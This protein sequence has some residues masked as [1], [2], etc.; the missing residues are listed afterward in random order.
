MRGPTPVLNYKVEVLCTHDGEAMSFAVTDSEAG[1]VV[2]VTDPFRAF[3]QAFFTGKGDPRVIQL[4][5]NASW[6]KIPIHASQVRRFWPYEKPVFPKN[7]DHRYF[8]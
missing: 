4:A 1:H 3:L 6:A 5:G 2:D 8:P 7:T